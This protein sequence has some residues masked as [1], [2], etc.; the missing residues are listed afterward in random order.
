MSNSITMIG[1]LGQDP[2]QGSTNSGTDYANFSI[3]GKSVRQDDETLWMRVTVWGKLAEICGKH[4]HKG[5][6]VAVFGSLKANSYQ[7]KEGETITDKVINADRVTFLG[8]KEDSEG[9]TPAPGIP[10]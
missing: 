9:D 3:A 1:R 7:N 5:S 2:T 8:K 6:E 10:F 4:L